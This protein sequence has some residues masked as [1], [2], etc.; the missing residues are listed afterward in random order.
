MEGQQRGKRRGRL[1]V[2]VALLAVLAAAGLAV[3][4]AAAAKRPFCR[5]PW[6]SN[7][8]QLGNNDPGFPPT[9]LTGV[10]A[11]RDACFDRLVLDLSG[12]ATGYRVEY[13][14]QV[15]QDGSGAPIP[16]RGGAFLQIVLSAAAH[17]Q[18]GRPTYRPANR[19]E[20]VDVRGFPT[21]RQAAFGGTFEGLTTLGLGVRARLPF[22]VL[23]LPLP[24]GRS[25]V[26]VD[27][28]HRWV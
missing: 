16:L 10:R 4:P 18:A 15:T 27:V 20:I 22:R 8:K 21:F 1:K 25:R 11:G 17:D 23:V 24:A 19:A 5:Q 28:S 6:G 3:A 13:V 26:V 12:P 7:A 2:V 14:P 9:L